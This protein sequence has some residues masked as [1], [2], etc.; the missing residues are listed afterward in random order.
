MIWKCK[1]SVSLSFVQCEM[2][3]KKLEIE[4]RL[5]KKKEEKSE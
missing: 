4:R 3:I 2:N 1:I 5:I